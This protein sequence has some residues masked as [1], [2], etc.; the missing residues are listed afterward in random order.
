MIKAELSS[1]ASSGRWY[2]AQLPNKPISDPL[3]QSRD[4]QERIPAE[5]H[6]HDRSIGH[7]QPVMQIAPRIVYLL[8]GDSSQAGVR[9]E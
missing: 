1:R 4:R 9:E 7:I 8:T 5:R 2:A 3:R 6:R